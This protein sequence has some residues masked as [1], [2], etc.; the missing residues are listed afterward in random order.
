MANRVLIV[1]D[2]QEA[3]EAM[4]SLIAE[5]GPYEVTLAH[6]LHDAAHALG[7]AAFDLVLLDLQL[8]DG[9]GLKLFEDGLLNSRSQVVLVTA[10]ATIETSV[11]ALRLRVADYLIKPITFKQLEGVLSRI[12]PA[13]VL[14]DE[15]AQLRSDW[16]QSGRFGEM[17]GRSA[18]MEAVYERVA[19]VAATAVSVFITGES[20]TGKELVARSV[21]ALSRRRNKPFLAVNCGAISPQLIESELFGH[22]KGSF[23]GAE[24][25]HKGF[26]EHA[27]G[28]TLFLDEVTE[29]PL[30]LQVK[31]LR[32]LETG[33]YMRVGS[34]DVQKADVRLIAACNRSPEEAVLQGRLRE[35]LLY[36]LNVFP[37]RLPPLR[38]RVDDI[39]LLAAHFLEDIQRTEGVPKSFSEQAM[40]GLCGRRWPGNVREL[41]NAVQRMYVM[42][43]GNLITHE[44]LP[45]DRYDDT[46]PADAAADVAIPLGVTIADAERQLILATLAHFE[47][48][49]ER[50]AASLGISLKTLY[51]RLKRYGGE[52]ADDDPP[53]DELPDDR[54][55]NQAER[56]A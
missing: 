4:K 5:V 41:R 17:W 24:R 37:V 38:E 25:R 55:D 36:R 45:R 8:P 42:S 21:H 43:P 2:D 9:S 48:Q 29:M 52:A 44:W 51:N 28:G 40:A 56:V 6:A 14:G 49:K 33:A 27:D 18:P 50:V 54:L 11:M 10:H 32:V 1:E 34:N 20:G 7:K 47:N 15:L 39:P 53:D 19:R 30:D 23:T 46:S 22:E 26:F 13:S 12:M 31:M 3:A 16:Q 35:D